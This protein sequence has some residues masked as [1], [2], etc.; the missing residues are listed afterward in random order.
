ME[1]GRAIGRNLRR[2]RG[3]AGR[4]LADLAAAADV[5]KTTLHE[6]EQGDANP[7][8][9]TLYAIA[10][11][12]GVGLADLLA[13]DLP[14]VQ[15]VRAGEGTVVEGDAVTAR[16]L[17]RVPVQGHIEVYAVEVAGAE[18]SSRAHLDHV[19]ECL[20]VHR[21][22]IVAGPEGHEATLGIG[23]SV[24][25]RADVDHGY[26]SPGQEPGEAT[27]IMIHGVPGDD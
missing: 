1:P 7:R 2:L 26:A 6:I 11:A 9:D 4:S 20:V 14:D 24:L 13:S 27:L 17:H 23:D 18:Q 16:L 8:L 12:L 22:E 15:V 25:F 10:S 3:G 19:R 21:G 5:S